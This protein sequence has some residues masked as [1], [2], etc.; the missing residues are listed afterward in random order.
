MLVVAGLGS[1]GD[2]RWGTHYIP[3]DGSSSSVEGVDHSRSF[4][5]RPKTR[6]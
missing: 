2:R 1:H 5:L 4:S 3:L 6:H